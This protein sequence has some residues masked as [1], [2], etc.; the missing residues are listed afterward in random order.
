MDI[1]PTAASQIA[2]LRAQLELARERE[3]SHQS[4]WAAEIDR[5]R[6]RLTAL[7]PL[8]A[9]AVQLREINMLLRHRLQAAELRVSQLEQ[10]LFVMQETGRAGE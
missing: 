7:E 10:Q 6:L 1:D 3:E 9:E 5:L 2:A 4:R 8:A